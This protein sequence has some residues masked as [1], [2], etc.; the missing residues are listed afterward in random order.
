MN[1]IKLGERIRRARKYKDLQSKDIAMAIGLKEGEY[2]NRYER[3]ER[4]PSLETL[5]EICNALHVSAD[6]LLADSL[7]IYA[8]LRED[9]DL[10]DKIATLDWADRCKLS[11]LVDKMIA[12][13]NEQRRD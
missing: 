4:V 9:S 7:A 2:F 5:V 6:F 3:A 11:A 1:I 8:D 12:I 10:F 13:Q